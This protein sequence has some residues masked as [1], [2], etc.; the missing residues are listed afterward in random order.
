MTAS[1]IPARRRIAH[2]IRSQYLKES[3]PGLNS[4]LEAISGSTM[5]QR[6][7]EA[8]RVTARKG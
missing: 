4:R 3:V 7:K 8:A 1:M 5:P 6:M 2:D